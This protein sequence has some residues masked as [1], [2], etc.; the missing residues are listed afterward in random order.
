VF[1]AVSYRMPSRHVVVVE[2]ITACVQRYRSAEVE[3]FV[4]L[5][6][7]VRHV[8][9]VY[10]VAAD[11]HLVVALARHVDDAD[12]DVDVVTVAPVHQL[13]VDVVLH[14]VY[15]RTGPD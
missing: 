2:E 4:R 11:D 15:T 6:G 9:R 8:V 3:Q 13:V 10:G 5:L 1:A 12:A 14:T 7:Q